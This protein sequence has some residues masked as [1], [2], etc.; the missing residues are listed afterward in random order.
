MPFFR[1]TSLSFR[2]VVNRKLRKTASVPPLP[3]TE[4]QSASAGQEQARLETNV[5]DAFHDP[6]VLDI[7][8]SMVYGLN[9][10]VTE[11]NKMTVIGS[12][13][14]ST[15]LLKLSSSPT[16]VVDTQSKAI[17]AP[18]PGT[19]SLHSKPSLASAAAPRIP[20]LADLDFVKVLG[21]GST[22]QVY[23]VH[24]RRTSARR[25]LKV[26]PHADMVFGQIFSVREEQ[27]ILQTLAM[28]SKMMGGKPYFSEL[29]ASFYDTKNFYFLMPLYPTDIESEII[30][31]KQLPEVR[32][33]F[34]FAEAYLGLCH[35]HSL[36][37]IHRDI[38]PSNLLLSSTGHV[39]IADFGL[40]RD[41]HIR[42]TLAERAFQPYWPYARD[43][44]VGP[45]TPR[46]PGDDPRLQ[47]TLFTGCG[48]GLHM[49]PE[50]LKGETYS[51]GVDFWALAISLYMMLTGRPPFDS[52]TEDFNDVKNEILEADLEFREDDKVSAVAQDF[53]SQMLEKCPEDR[54]HITEIEEHSFFAGIN[55]PLME[56]YSVPAPWIPDSSDSSFV[57]QEK[58]EEFVPGLPFDDLGP[59]PDFEWTPGLEEFD[60]VELV[61]A[62]SKEAGLEARKE[63]EAVEVA[64]RHERCEIG[65]VVEECEMV[66]EECEMVEEECE[67]VEEECEVRV[68][69]IVVEEEKTSVVRAL[70]QRL[71]PWSKKRWSTEQEQSRAEKSGPVST[72]TLHL[73][74]TPSCLSRISSSSSA[75]WQEFA[76]ARSEKS[77]S[78]A[79]PSDTPINSSISPE[80]QP[81]PLIVRHVENGTG[82]LFKLRVWFKRLFPWTTTTQL[83]N[84]FDLLG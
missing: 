79:H 81:Q 2:S 1:S 39:V 70:F 19:L 64:V 34:Y 32:S 4:S 30:R 33:C 62:R 37:I 26:V 60:E 83:V 72:S 48:T 11:V 42:P 54:R 15:C 44:V 55:W 56:T 69:E 12:P 52:E 23:L 27:S 57:L 73:P 63:E 49:A 18:T 61:D 3:S 13:A 14:A 22:A 29:D 71:W 80:R 24:N 31:C 41:F 10:F 5:V 45:N 47:F 46:R 7:R 68:K 36:G 50:L 84:R 65:D 16:I 66:E 21:I 78:S 58:P 77:L 20:H 40:S 67:M 59:Y 43:D 6:T 9:G 53:L 8:R 75:P 17:S 74:P 28:S 76:D 82:F 25:A 51:F 35:L 38:K